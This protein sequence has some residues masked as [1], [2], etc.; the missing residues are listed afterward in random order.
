MDSLCRLLLTLPGAAAGFLFI[1]GFFL[2]FSV[3]PGIP[4]DP[5]SFEVSFHLI[6]QGSDPLILNLG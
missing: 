3:P 1:Q 4:R 6:T 5:D 2:F